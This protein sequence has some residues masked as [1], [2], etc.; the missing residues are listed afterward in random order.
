MHTVIEEIKA[1]CTQQT[2]K[3][4]YPSGISAPQ[5]QMVIKNLCH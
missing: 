3:A 2:D 5:A 1:V 4:N